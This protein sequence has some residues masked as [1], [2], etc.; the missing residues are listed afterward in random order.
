MAKTNDPI[1]RWAEE[2]NRHFF[3]RRPTNGQQIQ[4]KVLNVRETQIKI[5]VSPPTCENGCH[6]KD[7]RRALVRINDETRRALSVGM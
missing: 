4:E 1:K 5:T 6:Q 2:P 3:Q 7:Q